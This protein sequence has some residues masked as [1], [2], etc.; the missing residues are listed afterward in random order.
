LEIY[1]IWTD[2]YML[3]EIMFK[4]KIEYN[5]FANLKKKFLDYEHSNGNNL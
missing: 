3:I 5:K 2:L 1:A 4:L